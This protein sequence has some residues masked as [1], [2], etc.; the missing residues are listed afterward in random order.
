MSICFIAAALFSSGQM[1]NGLTGGAMNEV[2]AELQWQVPQFSFERV[3]PPG[4]DPDAVDVRKILQFVVEW[5]SMQGYEYAILAMCLVFV[6]YTMAGGLVA[7]VYTDLIQGLLT[8]VLSLLMLPFLFGHVGGFGALHDAR[9]VKPGMF[10]FVAD[11]GVARILNREPITPIYLLALSLT[12]LVGVIAQPHILSVC[13]AARTELSSRIGLTMGSF[14]KRLCGVGWTLTGLACIVWYLG[15][16]SP[17]LTSGDPEDARLHAALTQR[18]AIDFEERPEKDRA[19]LDQKDVEFANSL[20]GRAA[21]DVL[22]KVAPGLIGLLLAGLL[23]SVMSSCDAQMVV[24]SGLFTEN[25]YRRIFVS[26]KSES[27]YLWVARFTGLLIVA[28]ALVLQTTFTDVIDAMKIVLKLPAAIGISM[29]FGMFW[30]RW[31]PMA[32]WVSTVCAAGTWFAMAAYPTAIYEACPEFARDIFHRV[33]GEIAIRESTQILTYLTVGVLTGIVT[34][35][36]T[37]PQTTGQLEKFF[38][39]LRTPVTEEEARLSGYST[40]W[41]QG[42]KDRVVRFWGFQFPV[43][44]FLGVFGFIG[45][46]GLVFSVVY[47]TK[48]LSTLL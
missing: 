31:N 23:A 13:G 45:A 15:A 41:N 29:W 17:L 42:P 3:M 32:V 19:P 30:K 33:D 8:I 40:P 7:A 9:H 43:P 27:H 6:I 21:H 39:L 36:V 5:R 47:G 16:Q 25:V 1:I 26:G 2:A 48:W 10:E 24:G 28:L 18:A 34:A 38:D 4:A 11:S 37:Q 22:P 20:F 14:L 35:F 44:S 46:W 12:V